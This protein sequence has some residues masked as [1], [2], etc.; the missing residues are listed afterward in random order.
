MAL[1]FKKTI[2]LGGNK[3]GVR[4]R[5]NREDTTELERG[6]VDIVSDDLTISMAAK[7]VSE[8]DWLEL[9]LD[10]FLITGDS[11]T[12]GGSLSRGQ[13]T[14]DGIGLP[15]LPYSIKLLY[16]GDSLTDYGSSTTAAGR[17]PTQALQAQPRGYNIAASLMQT[18]SDYLYRDDQGTGGE[19]TGE[20]LSRVGDALAS[21]ADVVVV[22]MGTNDIYDAIPLA[23]TQANYQAWIDAVS[24][25]KYVLIVPIPHTRFPGKDYVDLNNQADVINAWLVTVAA[26]NDKVQIAGVPTEYNDAVVLV[27]GAGPLTSD[28]IHPT[29]AGGMMVAEPT[30]VAL[31]TF[32]PSAITKVNVAPP[33][34]DDDGGFFGS[35]A[36]GSLP[37]GYR[38]VFANP[39]TGVGFAVVDYSGTNWIDVRSSGAVAAG[40]AAFASLEL[41]PAVSVPSGR[42]VLELTVVFNNAE[43]VDTIKLEADSSGATYGFTNVITGDDA[44][45][46]DSAREYKL[47]TPDCYVGASDT[48]K[49]SFTT[50]GKEGAD[51]SYRVTGFKVYK[52]ED[53]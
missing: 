4:Y 8:F 40:N 45:T 26:L 5:L 15:P 30:V 42:Y 14:D 46:F 32:F 28:G 52:V 27:D 25:D 49:A 51:L 13:V 36:T 34:I 3:T 38:G 9:I 2:P 53:I 41:L 23:T 17:D 24:A 37:T 18:D 31:D 10:D 29:H 35:G 6:T 43:F 21:D 7:P 47:R 20:I 48:I 11:A 50:T 19:T 16:V 39:Q 1:E 44:Q 12:T 33:I 22:Q